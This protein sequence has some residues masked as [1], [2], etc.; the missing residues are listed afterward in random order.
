VA[1]VALMLAASPAYAHFCMKTGW[2]DAAVQHAAESQAWLTKSD[3]LAFI[4]EAVEAG[5][6][7]EAGAEILR[8]QIAAAP[9]NTLFLGPGLL[10]GGTLKNGKGNTPEHFGYLDFEAADAACA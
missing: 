3:W 4:E 7:C 6:G 10:G 8:A 2:S 1:I 9:E 5:V